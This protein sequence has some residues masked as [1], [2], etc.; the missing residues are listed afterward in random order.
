[1]RN[2]AINDPHGRNPPPLTAEELTGADNHRVAGH[3]TVIGRSVGRA[4]AIPLLAGSSGITPEAW[5][6]AAGWGA[7]GRVSLSCPWKMHYLL[8]SE[9]LL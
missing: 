4:Q 3:P 5:S 9:L 2:W 1:M 7:R 6:G 8:D